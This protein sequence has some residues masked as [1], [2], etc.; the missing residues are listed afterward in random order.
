M[1]ELS[2]YYILVIGISKYQLI[3]ICRKFLFL[4]II[5]LSNSYLTCI[6]KCDKATFIAHGKKF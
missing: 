3:K 4:Y 1:L 5:R 6:F 2:F